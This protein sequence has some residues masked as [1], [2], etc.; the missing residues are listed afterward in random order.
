MVYD[1]YLQQLSF[2]PVAVVSKLVQKY[3]KHNYIQKE[4]Q[5]TQQY[6]ST[7]YTK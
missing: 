5:Y 3:E 2:H 6:R 1:I 7:E 4:K